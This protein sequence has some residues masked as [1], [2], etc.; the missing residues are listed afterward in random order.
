MEKEKITWSWGKKVE[1]LV[2]NGANLR[3][4]ARDVVRERMKRVFVVIR[5]QESPR[6]RHQTLRRRHSL[7][8]LTTPT[9][10][11]VDLSPCVCACARVCVSSATQRC[12]M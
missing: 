11:P 3:G 6:Y 9:T 10:T 5:S 4:K 12:E 2:R 8:E 7:R 1:Q